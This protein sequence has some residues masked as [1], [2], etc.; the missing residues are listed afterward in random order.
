M[1]LRLGLRY[2]GHS[3]GNAATACTCHSRRAFLTG[4]AAAGATAMLAP[5]TSKSQS[6]APRTI[7]VH[8]HIYPPKYLSENLEQIAKTNGAYA[9]RTRNWS[10]Q[11]AVEKMDQ[12]GVSDEAAASMRSTCSLLISFAANS[13][14]RLGLD[15][16]SL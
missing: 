7:D 6:P 11:S 1:T 5:A 3:I 9:A 12:A 15:W 16:L 13:E 8:H 4:A 10:A 2:R 14:A